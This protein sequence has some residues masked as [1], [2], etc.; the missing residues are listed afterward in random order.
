MSH[1]RGTLD[2]ASA[3]DVT[4]F[5]SLKFLHRRLWPRVQIQSIRLIHS[6]SPLSICG[7][8]P[9]RTHSCGALTAADVHSR[10]VLAGWTLP[11]RKVSHNLFFFSIKDSYGT[12]QLM[13]NRSNE[14]S[15]AAL[16]TLSQI[17]VE[18][19]VLVEGCVQMRPE[20]DQKTNTP[21][22]EIEVL[23]DNV[24]LLNAADH[25]H[26][27]FTQA[28][29]FSLANEE[30]RARYRHLDLRR[31]PMSDNLR[32][33]SNVVHLIRNVLHQQDFVEVETPLLLKSTPEGAREFLVPTRLLTAPRND[34]SDVTT[35]KFYALPQ[36]PQQPKQLLICSGA[37]DKYYQIARCFR[38]E[39][40][41]KDRQPEFTQVDLEMAFVSWG[42]PDDTLKLRSDSQAPVKRLNAWRIGGSEIR[43]LIESLLKRIWKE[44]EGI[45]LDDSFPVMTYADAMNEYGSD[46]PDTR[47]GLKIVNLTNFLPQEMQ[48]RL[49]QSGD[50]IE[51]IIL[52]R[53]DNPEFLEVDVD[54]CETECVTVHVTEK[55]ITC[56]AV[57]NGITKDL[58][59]SSTPPASYSIDV[60]TI[61]AT[62]QI[63]VGDSLL[64]SRR[65]MLPEACGKVSGLRWVSETGV[66]IRNDQGLYTPPAHPHFLW[67]TEFPLFTR[68]DKEKDA[69]AKGRWSS[70]HHPFTAP[71][72]QDIP[73]LFAGDIASVRA[74]H[75]D[76]VLNGME[77]GGGSVRIHDPTMQ[78]YIFTDVLK[79]T[80]PERE[81]FSHLLQ[82]LKSG[83]PPH[84][85]IALGLDRLMAIL[86][87]TQSIRDVIAFPKTGAGTDP[88]FNS[89]ST[90]QT[91]LLE[92][93][94]IA[95][96]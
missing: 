59:D 38:D 72:W 31:Q 23:I 70:S 14:K 61:N 46:K 36:S 79:L 74:Q 43:T 62:L 2:P 93:Y 51:C 19:V 78:E 56:W 88:Y 91:N 96:R 33:R 20:K 55:N 47:C 71:M 44:M 42:E 45:V 11:R 89:P 73:K 86:C 64:L 21:T 58:C 65:Q 22:G 35:T 75:Y 18:S 60:A 48:E 12:T 27:P 84:G 7:P 53:P 29:S 17:P 90:V 85:G 77:I 80:M 40:G 4:M 94:G 15:T 68:A 76:L 25:R 6:Q 67:V 87:K 92:Q 34:G 28:N 3:T 52:R 54:G 41:R 81:S 63:Q 16:E 82:A 37:V 5:L 24:T 13:A 50:I 69:L 49:E 8:F 9:E 83:A 1:S 57:S 39:D 30:L 26:M 10:V 32:K 95:V 66:L